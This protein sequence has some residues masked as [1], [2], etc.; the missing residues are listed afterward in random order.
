MYSMLKI[1]MQK[2]QFQAERIVL[3]HT[4]K[5]SHLKPMLLSIINIDTSSLMGG[6]DSAD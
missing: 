1:A 3:I 2:D 5:L 4:G 6:Q